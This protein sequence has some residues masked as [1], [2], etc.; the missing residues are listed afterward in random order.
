[1]KNWELDCAVLCI[2]FARPKQFKKVFEQ[3]KKA[4][5]R[6]LLLWQDGPRKDRQ[7]DIENIEKCRAIAEDIDWDCEVHKNYHESNMGC[8]PSTH[9]SHKWAFSIVDK[10]IILE[11][12]LVASQSFF[13]FC[14]EML[15]KYENDDRI[16]RICCT[17]LLGVYDIP[18]DYFFA[19]SGHSTGWASWRRV[20]DT[21]ETDYGFL[22]DGYTVSC[23]KG[24]GTD[25]KFQN[26]WLNVCEKRKSTGIPYWE[27]IVGAS[28]ICQ[29]QL[30]IYPAKNLISN[31][32][33]D[34]NSTHAPA[35]IK[36]LPKKARN[37][38]NIKSY[39]L[40]F[41]LKAPPYVIAD[42]VFRKRCKE[43]YRLTFADRLGGMVNKL[44]YGG[45]KEVKKSF[46]RKLK[47]TKG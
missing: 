36:M 2:F 28:T 1:M 22:S 24:G 30:V 34:A 6:V 29:S 45:I 46:E 39:E 37:F 41:P 42:E 11:D 5:P 20:A 13:R 40:E 43:V 7:D 21:W 27:E 19:P 4:K 25:N 38:F 16:C 3:V 17:N 18:Y 33:I 44:R 15:D 26:S 32:G 23:I 12:D 10:C 14:K 47:R 9:L 8:D 35:E 31:V